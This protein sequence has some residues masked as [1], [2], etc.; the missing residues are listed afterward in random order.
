MYMRERLLARRDWRWVASWRV[1]NW[2]GVVLVF[3]AS[4]STSVGGG[5]SST[6]VENTN[7]SG[8]RVEPQMAL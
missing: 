8:W 2:P 5:S 1:C 3:L 4:A 7:M 6:A